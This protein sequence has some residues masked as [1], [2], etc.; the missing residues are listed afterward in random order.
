[1]VPLLGDS[2]MRRFRSTDG[3]VCAKR[4]K[5]SSALLGGISRSRL[6]IL[7]LEEMGVP[8]GD[9][10]R[11]ASEKRDGTA[12]T[13]EMNEV[14]CDSSLFWIAVTSVEYAVLGVSP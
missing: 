14:W 6:A 10:G 13:T 5:N 3:P 9:V 1:M 8:G 7:I 4:S 2:S 11:L 12:W